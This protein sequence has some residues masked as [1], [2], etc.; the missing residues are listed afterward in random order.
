MRYSAVQSRKAVAAY[1]FQV[2]SYCLSAFQRDI[3]L[4]PPPP[5]PAGGAIH[6]CW[7]VFV[8]ASELAHAADTGVSRP[9][10]SVFCGQYTPATRIDIIGPHFTG[11]HTTRPHGISSNHNKNVPQ[12]SGIIRQWLPCH[13]MCNH[14]IFAKRV[15]RMV[16]RKSQ[17]SS[18]VIDIHC[19]CILHSTVM[20]AN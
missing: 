17:T 15:L 14:D 3:P 20:E 5:P 18:F 4:A 11:W 13:Y 7:G 6:G 1:S 9:D 16:G 8:S 10:R 19:T 2:S 12:V